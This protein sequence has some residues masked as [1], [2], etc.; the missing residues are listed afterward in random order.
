[1]ACGNLNTC[2]NVPDTFRDQ[3][4][5]VILGTATSCT[6]YIRNDCDGAPVTVSSNYLDLGGIADEMVSYKCSNTPATGPACL[7]GFGQCSATLLDIG[8]ELD[9]LGLQIC[10]NLAADS[11]N[12]GACG[13]S[14]S[15][16]LP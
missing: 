1:M 13:A 7:A 9:L 15:L 4:E 16:L 10:V 8:L 5:S 3:A 11:N 6:L 2:Y 12:C 14:V